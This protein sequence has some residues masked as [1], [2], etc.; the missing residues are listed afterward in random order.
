MRHHQIRNET[1]DPAKLDILEYFDNSLRA[2]GD[3][4]N[5]GNI[6][7]AM[8]IL[9]LAKRDGC[10]TVLNGVDGD[11][12]ASHGLFHLTELAIAGRWWE[13]GRCTR[14]VTS[15][16][17]RL[18]NCSALDIF[19]ALG[20]PVLCAKGAKRAIP[21]ILWASIALAVTCGIPLRHS[22]RRILSGLL[23]PKYQ[24]PWR[25]IFSTS[26]LNPDIL[27]Q[28]KYGSSPRNKCMARTGLRKRYTVTC[29]CGRWIRA[30]L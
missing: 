8:R 29:P 7:N 1:F 15:I 20:W 5:A 30:L 25:G 17:S 3:F 23:S 28:F 27:N 24:N 6:Y 13:F 10:R 22:V 16:Y 26:E 18:D 4:H 14:S 21:G 12:V 11:N 9:E 2:L 19:N